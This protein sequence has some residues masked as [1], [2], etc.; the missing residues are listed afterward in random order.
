MADQNQV[1]P[2]NNVAESYPLSPM[3]KGMLFHS[4]SA[5]HSGVDIEQVICTLSEK[6]DVAA[7]R[8][9]WERVVERHAVLRTG[10]HWGDLQPRQEV[11]RHVRLQFE[12]K[13]WRRLPEREQQSRLD[14][15]LQ[16]D[17]RRGFELSVPPLMRVAL[18]HVGEVKHIL[19]WNFHHLLLDARAMGA[20]L[21]EVFNFYQAFLER[22]DMELPPSR[23]YRDYIQRLQKRDGSAAEMFWRQQLKGF[24]SP[25][26][27]TLSRRPDPAPDQHTGHGVQQ[28]TLS[29]AETSRLRAVAKANALTVN[30]LLQGAWAVLL[31]RY[32]GDEDVSFGVVRAC[33]R[34]SVEGADAILGLFINTLPLRVRVPA[35]MSVLEWLKELRAQN[36]AMRD[37]EHTPLVEIQRWSEVPPGQRLFESLFDFQDPSWEAALRA[38]GGCWNKREFDI[39][40]QP[41]FPLWVDVYAGPEM[42]LKI[43]YDRDCFDDASMVRMLGHFRTVLEGLAA[44]LSRRLSDVPLLTDAERQQLLVGWNNTQAD[45]PQDK[46]VHELFEAQVE[47]TPNAVALV[48]GKEEVSYRELDN[49][50]NRVACHLRS[51][52]IGP[53]VPVGICM[54]RSAE[55]IVGLLGILKAGGAYVPLDPAYPKERIQFMLEDSRAPVLLTQEPLQN[56]FRFEE[57]GY[58]VVCLEA[59]RHA[60]RDTQRESPPRPKGSPDNLAYVIYT[61]GSTGTPKGVELSHR[62]L[63]NLLVWHQRTYCVTPKDR[64]TQLAGFSFDASVWELWPYLTAGASIHIVDDETRASAPALVQWLN[65]RRITLSFVPTPVAEQTLML[66]WPEGAP[67]RAML[68]GGDKLHRRPNENIPFVLVN[69]YGPTENTVVATSAPVGPGNH[70]ASVAPP[71][72]RPIA[73]VKTYVLDRLLRP[74]PVGV[75]GELYIGGDSLARGYRNNPALT[76]ERFVPHPFGGKTGA[77]LYKTGDLVRWLPDGNLEFLGRMDHQVKIRGYRIEPGEI[78]SR[79]NQHPTVRESLVLV[80][81]DGRGQKQLVAYLILKQQPAPAN[82]ELSDFLRAKLPDYM[83][84]SAFL[85]PDAWPLTPNGKVDRNAL[86][87]PDLS[88]RQP[89]QTFAAPRNQVEETVA[90]IWSEVLGHACVGIHDNFFELG[91]HSLV[92]AQAVSRLKEA[93]KIQL[94][95]RSLFEKPTVAGL[96]HEVERTMNRHNPERATAITRVA[97]EAYRA[98]H[99]SPRPRVELAKHH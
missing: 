15:Y 32:S 2:A 26:P 19:V 44:D 7:L 84:P 51:L 62:G 69:H 38:Q 92:A 88:T 12:H 64:A 76:T 61:S 24:T 48:Y 70:G 94:S 3:Q 75:P 74:V 46:C 41:S 65:A 78:E 90:R 97:R 59:L 31:S 87:A 83:V 85:F 60:K 6:L 29:H 45:Y 36:L 71:I 82:H 81:E 20:L 80:R 22:R 8:Q 67:L 98:N 4:L 21:N 72:G 95:I 56:R 34:S 40:H 58:R 13:D 50:A 14:A 49:Q 53:D 77:R 5:P 86:P 47:R 55:M 9:A 96:A 11:H 79:L 91:G 63:V 89:S 28:V 23:P 1:G 37:H 73:N 57:H 35:E 10:F 39:R 54:E 25:T 17:R 52:T 33:R 66:P 99:P 27:L 30:T 43:G 68:T 16:A 93:F 18:F 42:I